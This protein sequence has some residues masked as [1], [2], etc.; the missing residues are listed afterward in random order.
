MDDT[1]SSPLRNAPA[2]RRAT[3][4]SQKLS[5]KRLTAPFRSPLQTET[6]RKSITL[7]PRGEQ[8]DSQEPQAKRKDIPN[9]VQGTCIGASKT[10]RTVVLS[11]K[12][13][14]QF[15]SP[16]MKV[17]ADASRPVILPNQTIMNLE[18]KIATLRRAIKIKRDDDESH[19]DRLARKWRDA[20]REAAYE[21]WAIVRDLDMDKGEI[22]GIANDNGWGWD[23]QGGH[24][25]PGEGNLITEE[26]R[27]ENQESTLGMM[28]R[29]LG[30]APETLGWND[31][32]E[33]FVDDECE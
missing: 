16:L 1:M 21:L 33:T 23:D 13:A 11:S 24:G 7:T 6:S 29:K 31:E 5:R 2:P 22:R 30:I 19:L 28:L 4:A 20:G 18:R 25:T 27:Y 8:R 26:G 10:V 12:A 15:R 9:V 17:P 14:A 32:E 3:L